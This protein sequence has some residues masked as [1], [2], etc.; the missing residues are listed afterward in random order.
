MNQKALSSRQR[1][2]SVMLALVI[3][4]TAIS[5]IALSPSP[6]HAVGGSAYVTN[7]SHSTCDVQVRRYSGNSY[8]AETVKPGRTSLHKGYAVYISSTCKARWS[9]TTSYTYGQAIMALP[10]KFLHVII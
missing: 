3:A 6:A 9:G 10:H 4:L 1:L 5:V 7:S 8:A 2:M